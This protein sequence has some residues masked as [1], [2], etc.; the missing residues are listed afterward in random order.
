[1][2]RGEHDRAKV[3]GAGWPVRLWRWAVYWGG[4]WLRSLDGRAGGSGVGSYGVVR[5]ESELRMSWEDLERTL[6]WMVLN[7][8]AENSA[9]LLIDG[10]FFDN[11]LALEKALW[12][13]EGQP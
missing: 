12:R 1:M 8:A 6:C 11:A 5:Q 9:W 13:A 10:R 7:A 3:L 2:G 4:L